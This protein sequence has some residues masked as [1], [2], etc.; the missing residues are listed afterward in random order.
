METSV[1]KRFLFLTS[2]VLLVALAP[3]SLL[4][5]QLTTGTILGTVKDQTEAVLPGATVTVTNVETGI[6]RSATT[7]S[8]GEYRILA[9]AVG[10]YDIQASMA[11]FQTNVHKGMTLSIGREAVVDFSLKVGDVAEQVTVTG[12]ASA[13]REQTRG[14]HQRGDGALRGRISAPQCPVQ[15]ELPGRAISVRPRGWN[16]SIRQSHHAAHQRELRQ[17]PRGPPALRQR[18]V[19]RP[20]QH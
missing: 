14:S 15:P 5:A 7:G 12:E 9:L 11:G 6:V 1:N 16:G 8:R 3:G 2:L 4:M 13:E 18:L 20:V 10:T 19:L 17:R